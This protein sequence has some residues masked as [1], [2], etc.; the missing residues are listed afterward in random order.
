MIYNDVREFISS[1]INKIIVINK[2][3]TSTS[4]EYIE[5]YI[6]KNKMK[7]IYLLQFT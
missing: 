2:Q 7:S 4:I 6:P 5:N 3:L 1:L